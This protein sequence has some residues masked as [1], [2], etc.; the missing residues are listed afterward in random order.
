MSSEEKRDM[1]LR[2]KLSAFPIRQ[3]SQAITA[4]ARVLYKLYSIR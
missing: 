3:N 1:Q 4:A 2:K